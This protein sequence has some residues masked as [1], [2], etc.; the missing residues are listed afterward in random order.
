MLAMVHDY[1]VDG[2]SAAN[3]V[4]MMIS[5]LARSVVV[6]MVGFVADLVGFG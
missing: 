2:S 4:F 3:G 1:S 5:F 6:V